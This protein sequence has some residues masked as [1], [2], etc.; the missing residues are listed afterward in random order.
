MRITLLSFIILTSTCILSS[1]KK[2]LDVT[3]ADSVSTQFYFRDQNDFDQALVGLYSSLRA[4]NENSNNGSYGGNLYWNVASDEMFFQF[5]WHTPWFDVS[6]GNLN[7]NTADVGSI[8]S[9]AYRSIYWANVI[10]EKLEEKKS[11]LSDEFYESALGEAHFIRG[12]V[13]LRL[14]SLYGAVPLV[15]KVL[16]TPNEAKLPRTS[17]EEITNNLIVPDLDIAIAHL[18]NVP[19]ENKHGKATKQAAIGMKVRALLYLKNYTGTIATAEQLMSL[20]S[21]SSSVGFL[22]IYDSIFRNS[23]ENNK[24]ILFALKYTASGAK[25]GSTFNT[26]FGGALPGVTGAANGGWGSSAITPEL[27][28]AFPM[29]DGKLATESPLY[30]DTAKWD[31]R[32]ARFE[33]TFYIAGKSKVNGMVVLPD[34]IAAAGGAEYKKAYPVNLNK[35]YMNEDNKINWLNEDESDFI[36][37]RYTDVLLM[38]AEAKT[39]LNQIDASVYNILNMV[40]S[41][42]GIADVPAGQS[43]SQMRETIRKERRLEFAFEGLRYFDIRRWGIAK[44]VINSITSDETYNFGSRKQFSDKHY[45]WPV[46]Q[47]SIDTNPNLLPNNSGY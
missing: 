46:P 26:P 34:M 28:D 13:Y 24:E 23:N 36:I 31:N 30:T 10:I 41:R 47:S 33:N 14:T 43:Q 4:T 9:S 16:N 6:T 18:K 29:K 12:I 11:L 5:S 7:S 22:P 45:L 38:Y 32:G 20:A 8:W 17:V 39:E 37:I 25:Q 19:F 1:C 44:E 2:I 42:A 21:S 3:P 35:G 15:D 40:R 27:I